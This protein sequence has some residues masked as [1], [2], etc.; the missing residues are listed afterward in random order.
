MIAYVTQK[1]D[2]KFLLRVQIFARVWDS[3]VL[4][5]LIGMFPFEVIVLPRTVLKRNAFFQG[6]E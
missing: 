6:N 2:L 3:G 4:D 1:K 5:N